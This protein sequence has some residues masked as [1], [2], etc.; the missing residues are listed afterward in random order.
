MTES[1][2]S[3][4]TAAIPNDE[5]AT[6]M[7]CDLAQATP[8][9]GALLPCVPVNTDSSSKPRRNVPALKA[10]GTSPCGLPGRTQRRLSLG[11]TL[12]ITVR[13][14]DR[15]EESSGPA[16]MHFPRHQLS[17]PA[18]S[19][20]PGTERRL[21]RSLLCDFTVQLSLPRCPAAPPCARVLRLLRGRL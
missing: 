4:S 21:A 13:G 20:V 19:Y 10:S 3:F 18:L 12:R 15:P 2:L 9:K 8:A 7:S 1:A 14:S 17:L 11:R 5:Q 6:D 16:S